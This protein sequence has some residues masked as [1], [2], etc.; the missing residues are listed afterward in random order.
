MEIFLFD[1]AVKFRPEI[2]QADIQPSGDS[3][4]RRERLAHAADRHTDHDRAQMQVQRQAPD[5]VALFVEDFFSIDY[6]FVLVY[7]QHLN[8]PFPACKAF[9]L[10]FVNINIL[11]RECCQEKFIK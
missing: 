10:L 9:Q 6:V 8:V 11:K 2:H 1:I 3:P 7:T 5:A 4:V